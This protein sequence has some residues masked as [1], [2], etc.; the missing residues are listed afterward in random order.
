MCDRWIRGDWIRY[1]A[2]PAA[3]GALSADLVHGSACFS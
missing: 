1:P 2:N 3:N